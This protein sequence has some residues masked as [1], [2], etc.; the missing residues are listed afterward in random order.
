MNNRLFKNEKEIDLLI[1]T[2]DKFEQKLVFVLLWV[3]FTI[4]SCTYLE[5]KEYSS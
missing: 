5:T 1:K 3:F 4:T 2:G